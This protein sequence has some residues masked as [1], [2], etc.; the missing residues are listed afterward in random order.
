VTRAVPNSPT[1]FLRPEP[2]GRPPGVALT[3]ATYVALLIFGG[4]QALVGT[5]YY[6]AGPAP[7]ASVLF[8]F[9]ILATCL[10]GAWGLE[11]P[12]GGLAAA[13]GWFIVVLILSSGTSG[14]SVLITGTAAG[15]WF[16]FGGAACAAAG[17]VAAFTIWSRR[18]RGY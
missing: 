15:E 4:V 1:R 3:V 18:S 2:P 16:L 14:G 9:A 11:R 13:A 17:V 5:F 8:D 10:L 12:S 7:V 6:G